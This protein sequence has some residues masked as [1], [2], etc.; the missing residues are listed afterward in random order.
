MDLRVEELNERIWSRN[1][2]DKALAANFDPRPTSTK[3][4]HFGILDRRGITTVPMMETTAHTVGTNFNPGTHRAPPGSIIR[5]VDIETTLRN[6]YDVLRHGDNFSAYV[7]SSN[8]DL[9]IVNVASSSTGNGLVSH[10][11]LFQQHS[12]SNFRAEA[13]S[14]DLTFGN[15]T[16]VQLRNML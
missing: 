7:P 16:R 5:D 3:Y 10:P 13:F 15:N 1:V 12:H 2:P 6:Q 4:S 8:S 9:F 14:G 11:G